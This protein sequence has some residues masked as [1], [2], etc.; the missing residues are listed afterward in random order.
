MRKTKSETHRRFDPVSHNEGM[1]RS[2]EILG[3]EGKNPNRVPEPKKKELTL[4]EKLALN[5]A[6]RK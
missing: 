6:N 4:K 2:W 3:F 1:D 5:K